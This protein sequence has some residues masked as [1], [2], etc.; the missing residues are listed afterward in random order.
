MRC[1]EFTIVGYLLGSLLFGRFFLEQFK[2]I[3]VAEASRDGNPGTANAYMLGGFW[4]GTLTLLCDLSKGFLPV[5]TYI[6]VKGGVLDFTCV[7]VV[8]APVLGH[9]YSV[10]HHFTGGKAIAVSFGALLG[11][12]PAWIPVVTLAFYYIFFS[13]VYKIRSHSRRSIVTFLTAAA[14]DIFFVKEK[15]VLAA[16][17]GVALIVC[18]KHI[19]CEEALQNEELAGF[20]LSEDTAGVPEINA[21]TMHDVKIQHY[22]EIK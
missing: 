8:V 17:G 16:F 7:P 10:F 19:D 15:A 9:A 14:S 11:L 12:L 2:A 18:K 1:L 21:Q 5:F 22:R 13:V 6:W 20:E 4:C 3:D